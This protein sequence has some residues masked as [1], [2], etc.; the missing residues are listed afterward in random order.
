MNDLR[1]QPTTQWQPAPALL[2]PFQETFMPPEPAA[3]RP[4]AFAA[5]NE[6]HTPFAEAA[7]L[8]SQS[9]ADRMFAEA[10]D[11]L[12]DEAFDEALAF[13]AEETEQAVADR[14]TGESPS[15]GPERER[16]ADAYLSPVRFEAEQYLDGL[17]EGLGGM[18][19]ASLAEDQ[20]DEVLARFDPNEAE[21][22]PAG[23]EFIGKFVQKAKKAVKFVAKLASP[24]LGPVLAK[25]RKLVQPLLRR[26]LSM[27]IGRLPAPL[28]AAA[29][30]LATKITGEAPGGEDEGMSPANLT[31]V[32][33]LAESFDAA[34]AQSL[35]FAGE[36]LDYEEEAIAGDRSETAMES[37][38]LEALA[39]ARGAL[40]D[41]F[42]A[43][44]DE[45]D[46]GPAIEQF[47]PAV[48]G[49]LRLGIQLVG[50]PKVVSFLAKYV[51]QLIKRWVG[52][53]L[54]QPLSTAIVDTGLR[55]ATLEA[56][57]G[58]ALELRQDEAAPVALAS[59]VEDTVRRLAEQDESLLENEEL[60]QLATAEAFSQAV[61][62]HF[63]GQ[64][65]RPE[66]QQAP[67]LGGTF[68]ARRPRAIRTYRKYSRVPDIEITPQLADALP[69]FGGTTVGAALRAAGIALPVRAR[70]HIYQATAG[71]TIPSTL[72]QDRGAS[73]GGRGFGN[74]HP[75]T[76]AA[77]GLLLREPRLGVAV[78]PAYLQ[79]RNRIAAGQRFYVL[80]SAEAP[81]MAKAATPAMRTAAART[82]P[83]RATVRV[84]Q[85]RGRIT[86]SFYLSEV[87]AQ[88]IAAAIREGR[89]AA[90]LLQALTNAW[91]ELDKAAAASGG[92]PRMQ[93]EDE[94]FAGFAGAARRLVAPAL[95]AMLQRRLQGWLLPALAEWAKTGGEAFVRAAAH[96]DPGVTVRVTLASVPGLAACCASCG[97]PAA[98]GKGASRAR[99]PVTVTVHPGRSR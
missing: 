17:Q 92:A 49:A 77:A 80:E 48:L 82:A 91:R 74:A 6:G 5:W 43:A 47:V 8:P 15:A 73:S 56:E 16:Y 96:P 59:V 50:R 66:L 55:L 68:V 32:E 34:L 78:P 71:T 72:R 64:L 44:G 98:P 30:Q 39:A 93:R 60:M 14:F 37:R 84:N 86:A 87:E 90:A 63:P 89:G 2:N 75:L 85:R 9:E 81:G 4:A 27:A 42:R 24:L 1:T 83:S 20:L 53:Q 99:P 97:T 29:R 61:A 76:P 3:A 36:G 23:E 13:L 62:S 10:F 46:L 31:D 11:E 33:A 58:T 12:R 54:S 41:R 26:V 40:I 7:G 38:E 65:L 21:L 19:I 18:D 28:Q 51:A 52:P 95:A 67:T 94:D 79:S 35:A 25:L 70:L 57:S 22:T 88:A 69:A 45:E